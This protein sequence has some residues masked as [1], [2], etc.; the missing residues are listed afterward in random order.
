MSPSEVPQAAADDLRFSW[1][2]EPSSVIA[3][4]D[5][6]HADEDLAGAR[7]AA[8]G[9][10]LLTRP[11]LTRPSGRATCARCKTTRTSYSPTAT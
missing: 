6:A 4:L 7:A 2:N 5:Q 10:A 8:A 11:T 9:R 3:A 1:L